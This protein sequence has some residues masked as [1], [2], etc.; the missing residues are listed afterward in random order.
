[1]L[2]L[3]NRKSWFQQKIEYLACRFLPSYVIKH[4]CTLGLAQ[5]SVENAKHYYKMNPR[6]FLMKMLD[7]DESI[8]LCA[9]YLRSLME[10]YTQGYRTEDY[11]DTDCTTHLSTEQK[12]SLYIASEYICGCNISLRKFTLVYMTIIEDCE[13]EIS[14]KKVG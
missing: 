11:Q 10:K 13:P 1:M 9:Y 4:N 6:N 14:L 8:E 2:E 5:I 12:L 3:I 7:I